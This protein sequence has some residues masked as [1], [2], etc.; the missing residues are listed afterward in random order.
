MKHPLS[1]Q[2]MWSGEGGARAAGSGQPVA[3]QPGAVTRPLPKD[4]LIVIPLRNAVLFPGVLSPMTVGRPISVGAAQEVVK[5]E[6]RAGF[7]LQ[8][9]PEKADV[10]PSDLYWVG[11]AGPIVRYITGPEGTHHLVVQGESRFRV[12]EFLEGWP[13]LVARVAM[14][15]QPPAEGPEV[16]ARF[17]QLKERAIEAIGLLPHV[18]DELVG[19]VRGIESASVLAD[20]VANLIDAKNEEKQDILETFDLVRRLDKVIALLSARIE[21]LKLS[22]EIGEKTR[23]QFDERQREHVLRE[24][25]RQIQKELGEGEENAADLEELSKAIEA[26][27]MPAEV[28]KHAEKEFKRLQRS[29]EGGAEYSMLRTYLEWLTEVALEAGTAAADRPGRSAARARR[30]P[31]RP[32]Q[33]QAAHPGVP[34]GSQ[35]EPGGQE[36]DPVLRRSARR[37]Q[38]LARAVHRPRHRARIPES[39]S[40]RRARRG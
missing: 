8:R 16:E 28:L 17:L 33:D 2:Q 10:V 27:G 21:V 1:R 3:A 29:G 32:G 31:F 13:F 24:Q 12:L 20:I 4:A 25:L 11:T 15:E 23:A 26:A 36:S 38:D 18:P 6:L 19:V 37:G 40:G 34:G 14:I 7:L 9:D 35:A 39:R 22:K 30:G 5:R